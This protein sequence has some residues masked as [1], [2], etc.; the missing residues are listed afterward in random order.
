M[1]EA[2][3]GRK[4]ESILA[5]AQ[6][7]DTRTNL[8]KIPIN[9]IKPNP[10]Q[11]RSDYSESEIIQ[12]AQSI[13]ENGLLEP[14]LVR[15]NG[16]FYE[17][18][19]GQR[20]LLAVKRLGWQEIEVKILNVSDAKL[21]EVSLVENL[22]RKDLNPLERAN[23][24]KK[25]IDIF[26]YT[27]EQIAKIF[28]I[29]PSSVSHSLKL[30]TLPTPIK[31]YLTRGNLSEGHAKLLCSIQ[32]PAQQIHFAH[33]V[34]KEDLSVR[35]L[36]ELLADIKTTQKPKHPSKKSTLSLELQDLQT[37]LSNKYNTKIQIK[38]NNKTNS[39]TIIIKFFNTNHLNEILDKMLQ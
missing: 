2:R 18:I 38:I 22:E 39:G 37:K 8:T 12:L 26:G 33:L 13:K 21:C 1:V 30:L 32:D 16:E 35:K 3:F 11:A 6:F 17:I 20:R 19:A 5:D 10:Y 23:G 31:D 15:K 28:N 29:S 14:I 27:Q 7:I 24:Y 36:E 9:L 25:L 4:L 34:V